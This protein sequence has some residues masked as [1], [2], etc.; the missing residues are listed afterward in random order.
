[1][2]GPP[3]ILRRILARKS[4]EVVERAER[5]PL[6]ELSRR[7]ESAPPPRDFAAALQAAI[8][9]GRP[10]VIA[11]IK[12]ASPSRGLLRAGFSPA[13]LRPTRPPAF[14][15]SPARFFFGAA[16]RT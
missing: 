1:M 7:V 14:R 16:T 5:L 15:C 3:D 13:A 6:K 4:Q 2:N 8:A 12:K 9:T 10:A 11:E